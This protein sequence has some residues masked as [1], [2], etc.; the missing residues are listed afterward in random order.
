MRNPSRLHQSLQLSATVGIIATSAW[1]QVSAQVLVDVDRSGVTV[2]YPFAPG[3]I[4]QSFSTD[5]SNV[6]GAGFQ[7]RSF[8]G[9]PNLPTETAVLTVS[10]WTALPSEWRG[11]TITHPNATRLAT[12]S[13][14]V[15]SSYGQFVW[16]EVFWQPVAVQPGV[17]YWLTA[18]SS[19][20]IFQGLRNDPWAFGEAAYT[21]ESVL[22]PTETSLYHVTVG[23]SLSFRTYTAVPESEEYAVAGGM[24]LMAYAVWRRRNR[25]SAVS[26]Q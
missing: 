24:G 16:G 3:F 13:V 9:D 5:K 21:D 8:F 6:A 15:T 1:G 10:L 26:M 7:V 11:S 4:A 12:G 22:T 19:I 18:G 14:D 20:P 17:T 25:R 23:Q 2:G